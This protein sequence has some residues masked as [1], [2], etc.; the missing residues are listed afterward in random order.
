MEQEAEHRRQYLTIHLV[1][2]GSF[3]ARALEIRDQP[4]SVRFLVLLWHGGYGRTIH[5]CQHGWRILY[6]IAN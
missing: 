1:E 6:K 5:H 4:L 2:L 3:L